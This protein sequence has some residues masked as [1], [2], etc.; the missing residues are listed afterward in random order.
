MSPL[1]G[2]DSEKEWEVQSIC[3][4]PICVGVGETDI[5][6]DISCN[7][8]L[9]QYS[10]SNGIMYVCVYVQ[11]DVCIFVCMYFFLYMY[12]WGEVFRT[13]PDWSWGPS[14][15]LYNGYRVFLGGKVAGAWR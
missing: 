14:N 4:G 13:R 1:S 2:T 8:V 15:L 11:I 9:L 6:T 7:Y 10:V 3:A 5:V 12:G